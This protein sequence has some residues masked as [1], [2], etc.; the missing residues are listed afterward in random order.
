M[1]VYAISDINTWVGHVV[2]QEDISCCSNTVILETSVHLSMLSDII[3]LL[4]YSGQMHDIVWK[5][6]FHTNKDI[7]KA[8]LQ[9]L[10]VRSQDSLI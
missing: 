2:Y 3:W 1:T 7:S 4:N 6:H 9:E 10:K 8:Y 5:R